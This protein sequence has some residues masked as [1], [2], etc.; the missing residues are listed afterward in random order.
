MS[1]TILLCQPSSQHSSRIY[2]DYETAEEALDGVCKMFEARLKQENPGATDL[3]YDVA[4]LMDFIDSLT[5]ISLM[6]FDQNTKLY[7]PFGKD[8]VK[9]KVYAHLKRCAA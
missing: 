6:V 5:D 3:Q 8:W 1:H 7:R 4:D 9:N 2:S